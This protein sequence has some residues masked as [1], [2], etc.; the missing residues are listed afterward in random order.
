[1]LIKKKGPKS[2]PL[3]HSCLTSCN[4]NGKVF[5]EKVLS[6][7]IDLLDAILSLAIEKIRDINIFTI[8]FTLIVTSNYCR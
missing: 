8:D 7:K 6:V 1:M 4:K 3:S 5:L 2:D